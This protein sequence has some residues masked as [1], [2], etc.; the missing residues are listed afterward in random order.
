MSEHS[1]SSAVERYYRFHA[2]IYDMT[3]WS[4]LFGRVAIIQK[5]AAS[6]G[7]PARILE[8]GCGTGKNLIR[9]CRV[10][11]SA[12]ITGLD[13]SAD[14][15][16]QAR[17]K[18]GPLA[19]RVTLLHQPYERPL[20]PDAPYDVVLFSYSL[21]MINPGW[22]EVIAHAASDLAP[23][24]RVAVVDFHASN[25]PL[26]KQW[27]K[28]NHVQMNGHLLPALEQRF[29]PETSEVHRAYSGLW[30]YLLFVGLKPAL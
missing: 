27:M 17:R 28:R 10:F 13:M 6:A 15:L 14:M 25:V 1:S 26:F 12:H 30:Q 29:R 7:H 16:E 4:F 23:G 8:V 21:S 19:E 2:H 11:P 9:L 20:Q 3:R 18:L 22:D 24:G 5:I